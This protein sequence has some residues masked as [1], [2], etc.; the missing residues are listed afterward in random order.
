MLCVNGSK[1]TG[2]EGAHA[3]LPF[4]LSCAAGGVAVCTAR[5]WKRLEGVEIW[6][7]T[8]GGINFGGI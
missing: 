4:L 2:G 8:S 7:G 3:V 5:T 6:S 1:H